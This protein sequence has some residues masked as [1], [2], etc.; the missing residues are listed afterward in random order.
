M[1]FQLTGFQLTYTNSPAVEEIVKC[2]DMLS[3]Q[4]KSVELDSIMQITRD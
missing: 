1:L 4:E 3:F 2:T